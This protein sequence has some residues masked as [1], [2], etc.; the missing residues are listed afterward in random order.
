MLCC[1]VLPC[2]MPR[3]GPSDPKKELSGSG[4]GSAAPAALSR[5][6]GGGSGSARAR[7]LPCSGCAVGGLLTLRDNLLHV[8]ALLHL[9]SR[10]ARVSPTCNGRPRSCTAVKTPAILRGVC[11]WKSNA[12]KSFATCCSSLSPYFFKK[13][14]TPCTSAG[15]PRCRP[16]RAF[17]APMPLATAC[18]S[19]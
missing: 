10:P 14:S 18:R 16:P 8:K 19:T 9:A 15:P 7:S 13:P 12:P 1:A 2:A 4:S 17:S 6:R 3:H 11:G 5:G